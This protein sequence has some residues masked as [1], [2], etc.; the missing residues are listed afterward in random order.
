M[1]GSK[2]ISMCDRLQDLE[3]DMLSEE[4]TTHE[5]MLLAI[6]HR[7]FLQTPLELKRFVAC[8]D[9]VPLDNP[10]DSDYEFK[11]HHAGGETETRCDWDKYNEDFEDY[12]EALK[13][14]WFENFEL[15]EDDGEGEGWRFKIEEENCASYFWLS[16][17]SN[18]EDMVEHVPMTDKKLT[19]SKAKELGLTPIK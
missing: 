9:G 5:A 19:Q 16:K 6:K 1:K 13:D 2:L 3:L 10:N 15:L 11:Y 8:K 12:E 7:Q 4:L 14:V 18:I 17:N